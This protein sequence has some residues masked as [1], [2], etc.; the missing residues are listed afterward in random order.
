MG[1]RQNDSYMGLC[2]LAKQIVR[3]GEIPQNTI[4][5]DLLMELY[6][7]DMV[8]LYE[9]IGR[10]QTKRQVILALKKWG[11]RSPRSGG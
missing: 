10:L 7:T 1:A 3:F 6:E 8:V 2:V 11:L 4:T 5:A 9:A